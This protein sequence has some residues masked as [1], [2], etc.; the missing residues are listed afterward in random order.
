M[1]TISRNAAVQVYLRD[2]GLACIKASG[3]PELIPLLVALLL[4]A[5]RTTEVAQIPRQRAQRPS[6]R[7]P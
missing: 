6:E 3:R 4:L 1:A 2:L 7:E 5:P